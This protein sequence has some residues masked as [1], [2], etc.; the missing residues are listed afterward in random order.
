MGTTCKVFNRGIYQTSL[1]HFVML[2]FHTLVILSL[3]AVLL[4]TVYNVIGHKAHAKLAVNIES[5]DSS[6]TIKDMN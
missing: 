1:T 2:P 6:V 3:V 5:E 4:H